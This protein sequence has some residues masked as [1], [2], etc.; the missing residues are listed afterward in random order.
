MLSKSLVR[1]VVLTGITEIMFDRYAGDNKTQLSPDQKMYLTPD[2]TVYLPSLNIR[3]FL[4]AENTTSAPKMLLD[5]REYKRVASALAASISVTPNVIP[6]LR[7]GKP[8]KFGE[9]S[10]QSDGITLDKTSGVQLVRHV[11][12]LD[13]GIP[14]PKE[15]PLLGLDWTLKFRLAVMPHPELS[16]EMIEDLFTRGGQFLG[17]GTFR[18][19]YGKFEF[20]W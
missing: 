16:E 18:K 12:R 10:E 4:T 13:K 19:V 6:F 9:F 3:S 5:S 1:D 17:L 20:A 14:N 7:N 2:K 15:R 11:A 8:I